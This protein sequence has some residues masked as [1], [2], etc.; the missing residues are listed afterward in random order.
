MN[1]VSVR[2]TSLAIPQ[3]SGVGC[4]TT[5][6]FAGCR[7]YNMVHDACKQTKRPPAPPESCQRTRHSCV[8]SVGGSGL[9]VQQGN[10]RKS[11]PKRVPNKQLTWMTWLAREAALPRWPLTW[12][13][14]YLLWKLK[15]VIPQRPNEDTSCTAMQNIYPLILLPPG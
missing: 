3:D 4:N 10:Q 1:K 12:R 6:P 13:R 14:S 8:N 7:H 9:C 2:R 15:S 11:L 5:S